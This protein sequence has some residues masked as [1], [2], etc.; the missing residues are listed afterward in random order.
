M[1]ALF[2]SVLKNCNPYHCSMSHSVLNKDSG[3]PRNKFDWLWD[4]LWSKLFATTVFSVLWG[5]KV[6]LLNVNIFKVVRCFLHRKAL[7][8]VCEKGYNFKYRRTIYVLT[9]CAYVL[10]LP[11]VYHS[12]FISCW[13]HGNVT[14]RVEMYTAVECTYSY[15]HSLR[16]RDS[17]DR[18]MDLDCL[19]HKSVVT[20]LADPGAFALIRRAWTYLALSFVTHSTV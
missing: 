5:C 15:V 10:L 20:R 7:I 13:I 2:C 18:N 8:F 17:L 9:L 16:M 3:R 12:N 1:L 6:R 11:W 14:Q 19:R 4:M